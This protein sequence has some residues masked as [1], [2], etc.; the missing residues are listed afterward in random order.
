MNSV[1]ICRKRASLCIASNTCKCVQVRAPLCT[2]ASDPVCIYVRLH[3]TVC[4]CVRGT[5]SPVMC[6][7]I[8]Y[9]TPGTHMCV[10]ERVCAC[11][12]VGGSPALPGCTHVV[13]QSSSSGVVVSVCVLHW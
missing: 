8:T 3:P 1:D 9:T 2:S 5:P 7:P 12:H 11:G 4:V 6:A 13:R 10:Y